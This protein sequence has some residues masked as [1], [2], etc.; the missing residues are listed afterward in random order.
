MEGVPRESKPANLAGIPQAGL[1]TSLMLLNRYP[2]T[3][4]NRNRARARVV[5]DLFLDVDILGLDGVR[6][7][8]AD[9]P[10]AHPAGGVL[11][12]GIPV[13][14]LARAADPM[15]AAGVTLLLAL[16]AAAGAFAWYGA[17]LRKLQIR[18]GHNENI[19]VH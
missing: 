10:L 13:E 15:L 12:V 5:Y 18:R 7:L 1:L 9:V 2:T 3:A 4:T 14:L 6:R 11:S 8:Q 19:G 17:G 16:V